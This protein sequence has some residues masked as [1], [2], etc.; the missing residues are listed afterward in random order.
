ML[1]PLPTGDG[2]A[3]IFRDS[4]ETPV[5]CALEIGEAL[6]GHPELPVRMGIHS[7]PV[8]EVPDVNERAN[9]AGAG[10]NMAQRVM[11]CGDAGHVLLSKRVA[12]DLEQYPQW[13]P[14]LHELG[15]CEV[16][17]GVRLVVVSL[18]SEKFGN[19]TVPA[20]LQSLPQAKLS[21]PPAGRPGFRRRAVIALAVT[22]AIAAAAGLWIYYGRSRAATSASVAPSASTSPAPAVEKS[23]AVLPFENLSDD[24]SN[25]YFAD[26][27]QDQILTKLAG[28]ADLKVISRISTAKYKSKPQDLKTVSQQLG[29]ATVLEGTVQRA[30]DR[31]RV[32]VQLIDAGADTPLWA[33][34]YDRELKDVFAVQSE[35]AQEIAD[36]LRAKLSPSETTAL[37]VAPTHD[38]E[39]YDLFL[40][41]EYEMRIAESALT[42]ESFDRASGFYREALNRDPSFALAAARL[43]RS[44]VGR[45]WFVAPFTADELGEVK[46]IVDRAIAL[47]PDLAEAHV[48][49]AIFYYW[50]KREYEAA[51]A[52]FQRALELQPNNV[53]AWQSRAYVYRRQGRWERSLVG[54]AKAAELDPRDPGIPANMAGTYLNLRQWNEAKRAGLRSLA[55]DPHHIVGMSAVVLAL[56]NGDGDIAAAKR[57]IA[58]IPGNARTNDRGSVSRMI[59]YHAFVHVVERDFAGALE[60]VKNGNADSTAD[61]LPASARAAICVFAGDDPGARLAGEEARGPLEARLR[62]RPDDGGAM[63]QLSWVYVALGRNAD[64]LRLAHQR[65][66]LLPIKKDA[67]W[68]PNFE[69]GLVEIQ[70]HAGEP[71]EAIKTL[72]RLLTIPAGT[73]VSLQRLK[74]DPVWDPIRNDPEFQ[75]LLAGKEQ[76]GPVE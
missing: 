22:T 20:K 57:A 59:G 76:I 71:V 13:R 52:E 4:P 56:I 64:A 75:K 51:L 24:K 23:I 63:I 25:A 2:M 42:G 8:S 48:S 10:I 68:G 58:T 37:A 43:A 28:V 14:H 60:D 16:K 73:S 31:V 27:V 12:D 3:L 66:A 74:I 33:R 62:E 40:R 45:H 67:Y 65:A 44:R 1:L 53:M 50:G 32:N 19:P 72:G 38:P 17:H 21:V 34:N 61:V 7:G 47:A 55:I 41:G 26:G 5:R 9:I 30:G 18:Y 36:A 15:E 46:T 54:L 6:K 39:A 29:V 49:L 70:V 35:V 11:D 69:T